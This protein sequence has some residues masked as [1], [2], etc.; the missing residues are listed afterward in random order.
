MWKLKLKVFDEEGLFASLA[1]KYQISIHG[2]MLNYSFSKNNFY[3]NLTIHIDGDKLIRDKFFKDLKAS[4]KVDKIENQGKFFIC[5]LKLSKSEERER[6]PS[7]F[8]NPLLIQLKPFIITPD[9]WEEL[10]FA[11]FDRKYLEEIIKISEKKYNLKLSYIKEEKIENIGILN[12]LPKLTKKQDKAVYSAINEGYYEYPRK[13]DVKNLASKAG[14]SFSTFQE[15]LR[16][17]ENKLIPFA[18]KKV[19]I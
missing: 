14:V 16:K 10:E 8:Y 11:S 15:H 5:R 9:G 1:M 3:F 4:K 18:V 13:I 19:E 2:Y 12:I 7:L 17:A 6:K